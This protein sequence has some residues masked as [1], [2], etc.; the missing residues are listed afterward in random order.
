M[1]FGAEDAENFVLGVPEKA[2]LFIVAANA[3]IENGDISTILKVERAE[4]KG[5]HGRNG[6]TPF[7]IKSMGKRKKPCGWAGLWEA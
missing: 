6:N 4:F 2:V 5:F 3:I 7:L 1:K